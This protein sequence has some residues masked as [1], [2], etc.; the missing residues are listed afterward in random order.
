MIEV[1]DLT[2]DFRRQAG[3]LGRFRGQPGGVV[4]A[5]DGVS[6]TLGRGEILGLVGESGCGKTTLARAILHLCEPTT[7]RIIFNGHDLLTLDS[8]SLKDLR[9]RMQMVFQ[10]S[11]SALD[12]RFSV[13][14]SLEEPLAVHGFPGSEI[15][16]KVTVVLNRVGL[17]KSLLSRRPV[18]LSGGQRQRV[19]IARALVLEPEFVVLDEPL[20]G[21]DVSV[22][23]QLLSLLMELRSELKLSY[24]LI[25]H[26]LE[27]TLYAS[28]RVA[29]MRQGRI[30]EYIDPD[31]YPFGVAHP[32]TMELF[33]CLEPILR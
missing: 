24:L 15:D 21:L 8:R 26:E 3:L 22:K 25:S 28:D 20:A 18:E 12:P 32:Y 23:A 17:A 11:N 5:V 1:S 19:C 7:G 30:V 6:L 29:V 33:S 4:R 14:Q 31:R 27:S 9:R 13:L 16:R 10:D 2:V